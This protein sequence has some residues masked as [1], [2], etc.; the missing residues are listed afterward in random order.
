M[1]VILI[2]LFLFIAAAV[3]EVDIG[4]AI[5]AAKDANT[6]KVIN[7]IREAYVG[8]SETTNDVLNYNQPQVYEFPG[9]KRLM[10]HYNWHVPDTWKYNEPVGPNFFL[11]LEDDHQVTTTF[12]A[13]DPPPSHSPITFP[14]D[15]PRP[16]PTKKSQILH[17]TQT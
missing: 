1:R 13:P 16:P 4:K 7:P 6:G 10:P 8:E 14:P 5:N 11:A 12:K 17:V 15:P 2:T 9:L 3:G